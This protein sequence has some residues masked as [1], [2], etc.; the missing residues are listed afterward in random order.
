MPQTH[1]RPVD[2]LTEAIA[3]LRQLRARAAAHTLKGDPRALQRLPPRRLRARLVSPEAA[4]Y[5]LTRPIAPRS[6]RAAFAH[7]AQPVDEGPEPPQKL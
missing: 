6:G 2:A 4:R 1:T 3:F 5:R 7:S